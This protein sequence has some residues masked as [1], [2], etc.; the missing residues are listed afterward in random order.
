MTLRSLAVY[1]AYLR[2]S[3]RLRINTTYAKPSGCLHSQVY[4]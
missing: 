1:Y 4:A 3:K 2:F